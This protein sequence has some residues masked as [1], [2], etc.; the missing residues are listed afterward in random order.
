MTSIRE[1]S[2][3]FLWICLVGF[4]LSLVGVM[5]TSGQGF[6]GG[7]SLTSLFSNSV[8]PALHVGKVGDKSISRR[9]FLTELQIQRNTQNQFQISTT[10]QYYI[11]RAWESI[12][13]N[14]ITNSKIEELNL[15]TQSEELKHYLLN[16]PPKA[17]EDFLVQN[18]IFKSDEGIFDL[19]SYQNAIKNNISWMPD[20]LINIFTNY[21]FR[22]RNEQIPRSKLQHL[23]SLLS[24]VPND[25]I[26]EE[27]VN[28][29]SNYNI[30][31]LSIDYTKIN[32]NEV[33][34]DEQSIMNYY[35]NNLE[36]DFTNPASVTVEYIMFENIT[37]EDDSLEI[38]FNEEQRQ[39][40]DDFA[41]NAREDMLG[42]D[43]ALDNDSLQITGTLTLYEDF[44]NNSGLPINM[45][46]NRSIIRFAFDNP[47]NTVS[48]KVT[49]Q[50]GTAV[51]RIVN[52]KESYNKTIDEVRDEIT[53][54]LKKE[55][56]KDFAIN[57]MDNKDW[58]EIQNILNPEPSKIINNPF[59]NDVEKIKNFQEKNGLDS[60]G[61]WGPASQKKYKETIIEEDKKNQI[62][63]WNKGEESSLNG[64]FKT[65][66]KNYKIMG[67][68]SVMD[69]GD[70]SKIIESSNKLYI[71]KI[72][73]IT[74][75]EEDIDDIKYKS[76]RNKLISTMS[77]T[78]FNS[79]IQYMRKNIEIIDIRHK[80]I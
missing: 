14:T 1:K 56:K 32:D 13:Q 80:S 49:T 76:I 46:Y 79:W 44:A 30:D 33:E 9:A 21:E 62:V 36:D 47:I 27:Y 28:S 23:Y 34:I 15:K 45:G 11:G 19:I 6:L 70:L 35:N 38:I 5:G 48:D 18:N 42:F 78:I 59:N 73:N 26:K 41:F 31:I 69:E 29:N 55:F 65:F 54:N 57:L 10:E 50:N 39:R 37:N 64:S 40:A 60:D 24:I 4:I 53:N 7:A 66:G 68:L 75:S 61:K 51:F 12:I 58:S 8:N 71:V 67:S 17:L 25:K 16:S 52:K 20:S 43:A 63:V 72:N 77:N 22:L 2:K 74:Y 3:I